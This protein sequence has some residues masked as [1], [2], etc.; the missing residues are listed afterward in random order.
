M[1]R[2]SLASSLN[3]YRDRPMQWVSTM[4][5]GKQLDLRDGL[6]EDE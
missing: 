2:D 4:P 3:D 5:D 1:L 6:E